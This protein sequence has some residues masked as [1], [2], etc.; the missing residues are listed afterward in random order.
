MTDV[1]VILLIGAD[2][3]SAATFRRAVDGIQHAELVLVDRIGNALEYAHA[4]KPT[5]IVAR[6]V[7]GVTNVFDIC[8]KVKADA[9]LSSCV[10]AV[11]TNPSNMEWDR[12]FGAGVEGVLPW[13]L[14]SADLQAMIAAARRVGQLHHDMLDVSMHSAA[15]APLH[16][17]SD[18]WL[19]A[20]TQLRDEVQP[21]ARTRAEQIVEFA[22]HLA[23]QFGIPAMWLR[24]LDRAGRFAEVG[25]VFCGRTQRTS[26][27][28]GWHNAA[29][30]LGTYSLLARIEGLAG[31]AELTAMVSENWNGSGFPRGI[32]RADIPLRAR[33]LRVAR[34]YVMALEGGVAAPGDAIQAGSGTLYDPM[35]IEHFETL[36]MVAHDAVAEDQSEIVPVAVLR[37]GMTLAH[38]VFTHTGL[39]LLHEGTVLTPQTIQQIL[40][41]H[42]IEPIRPGIAIR[43]AAAA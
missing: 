40:R 37:S 4:R 23:A 32:A 5:L 2:P 9:T 36:V 22:H 1:D 33:I 27:G 21:G 31:A 11:A 25:S 43:R 10:F 41:V 6:H 19:G 8:R 39:L 28:L 35:V 26:G 16:T 29:R 7:P 15:P 13:P 18:A 20:L 42:H 14:T 34:D 24:D 12:A 17:L 38:D 30:A 3:L